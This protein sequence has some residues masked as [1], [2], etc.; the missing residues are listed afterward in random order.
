M[1]L[2]YARRFPALKFLAVATLICACNREQTNLNED[3]RLM[4][5]DRVGE[6][7][8]ES[9]S[10]L[11]T[12][13]S[14][15]TI[16]A[17]TITDH[18]NPAT[19]GSIAWYLATYSGGSVSQ[20]NTFYLQKG[21]TYFCKQRLFIP[22]NARISQSGTG[23]QALVK[24]D[25]ASYSDAGSNHEFIRMSANSIL[26]HF[27][28][29]LK[30]MPTNGI[31]IPAGADSAKLLN[32]TIQNG[33]RIPGGTSTLIYVAADYVKVNNCQLRRAGCD[34]T[35]ENTVQ[36]GQMIKV[37][38]SNIEIA[39]NNMAVSA[40]AGIALE[41]SAR[42]ITINKDTIYDTGRATATQ[43]GI[44]SYHVGTGN[45][46][47][48]ISITNCLIYN[49]RN[50]GIHV[51]GYGYTIMW[52]KVYNAGYAGPTG[53]YTGSHMGANIWLGDYKTP[54]DCSGNSTITNNEIGC[55][56]GGGYVFKVTN[57]QS[58]STTIQTTNIC[59]NNK[60]ISGTCN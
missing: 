40:Q 27:N 24:I 31:L 55:S 48:N 56:L 28:I 8:A 21:S 54:L 29:D 47:R 18:G 33:K 11:A 15:Y 53:G 35:E 25:P 6:L 1:K 13:G 60:L 43:D 17:G 58:S 50:H 44:T 4:T 12:V 7:S 22:A 34:A 37:L 10:G 26:L 5:N 39:H 46:N 20:P 23:A 36:G 19:T 16:P 32:I 38:G 51:S 52:N 3:R 30:W 2:N 59:G 41:A 14:S 9:F 57:Y 49:S 45:T 42:N